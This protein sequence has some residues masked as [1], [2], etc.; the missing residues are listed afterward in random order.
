MKSKCISFLNLILFTFFSTSIFANTHCDE[1]GESEKTSCQ[2]G[3]KNIKF[4]ILFGL[5]LK[6]NRNLF[7]RSDK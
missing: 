1:H 5:I 4:V 3:M 6:K 7:C 2:T